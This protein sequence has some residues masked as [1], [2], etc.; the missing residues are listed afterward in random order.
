MSY[1]QLA[2]AVADL[3]AYMAMRGVGAGD[4]VLI[5]AENNV[6]AAQS[7]LACQVLNAWPAVVNARL[8]A[9]EIIGLVN[10]VEPRLMIYATANSAAAA[11]HAARE[12]GT[13]T[14]SAAGMDLVFGAVNP[15]AVAEPVAA[16]TAQRVG[17]LI[18]TSGTTGRPKAVMLGQQALASLGM[19]L[20]R[21]RQV[22]SADCYNGVAPLSHIMGIANL[23][24]V[25]A[26][27]ASLRLMPR[28][29][30]PQIAAAIADGEISH[31][32]FVPTVYARLLDYIDAHG[33]DVSRHRL[34]YISCGGAPLDAALQGRVQ[35]RFGI[36]LVNGYGMTECAPGTR[37]AADRFSEP[38]SI[39]HPEESVEVR[40]V[41]EDGSDVEGTG[42]GELWMRTPSAMLGY[43]RDPEATALTLRPGGWIATGDLGRRLP[44]GELAIVGRRKE[45]IIRSGFNFYP[46]EVEAALNSLPGVAASGVVGRRLQDGDEQV[47]AWVEPRAGVK[48]DPVELDSALKSLIAPYKRP[49]RIILV[50][51]LP[52][53]PTGKI[54]KAR[55]SA[56]AADLNHEAGD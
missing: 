31:L 28:L 20:S 2:D 30:M 5:I 33:I 22:K 10:L 55:L 23:M 39:G 6:G 21:S 8:P 3:A 15:A 17:L 18:F 37:T 7:L 49:Q 36:P 47:I 51:R 24:C 26:V 54:W 19:I 41:A 38:G 27:G 16:N 29:E 1:S 40:I 32:S 48:L 43:Y 35:A 14:G 25:L 34:H 53:G 13:H 52:Q 46:A 45:M 12:T 44:N 56:M 50:D 4:R 9:V 42:V 11:G